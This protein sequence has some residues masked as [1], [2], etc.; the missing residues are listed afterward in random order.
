M[1][2]WEQHIYSLCLEV[3]G[4]DGCFTVRYHLKYIF[5]SLLNHMSEEIS[6]EYT[7][8]IN[9]HYLSG[10]GSNIPLVL[11]GF[12]GKSTGQCDGKDLELWTETAQAHFSE[13]C[14][15]L[16]KECV[17]LAFWAVLFFCGALSSFLLQLPLLNTKLFVWI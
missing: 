5:G 11:K 17:P 13:K 15:F 6:N 4:A 12:G 8:K 16:V 1:K 14:L 7:I 3:A 9:N 10:Q 2:V